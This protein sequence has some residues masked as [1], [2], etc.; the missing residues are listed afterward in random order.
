M[1]TEEP[2]VAGVA[3]R[4]ASA[5]FDLAQE[6]NTVSEVEQDLVKFQQLYDL[7]PDFQRLIR[8]PVIA[9]D[10][11]A[12]A[13]GSVLDKA[14]VSSLAKN[15]FGLVARNRR[16]F[17]APQMVQA[18]LALAAKA[19]GEVTANVASAHPLTDAQTAA[20]KA[21]LEEKI[22]KSVK[23]VAKVDPSLIGGLIVK[24]GSRMVDSSLRTKLANLS[25]SLKGGT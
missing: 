18:F 1:A 24:L 8:S 9:A 10:E 14:G 2:I 5:L 13:I 21:A 15:F 25:L 6:Q 4:Y 19:R 7:S 22:G 20:L 11:Q 16:L 17:V 23:L 3:G 12:R